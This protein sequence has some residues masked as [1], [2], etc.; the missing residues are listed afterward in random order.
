MGKSIRQTIICQVQKND[1]RQR[2]CKKRNQANTYLPSA[3]CYA[4][5]KLQ[6]VSYVIEYKYFYYVK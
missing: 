4:L 5:N 2:K 1:S 3:Q 6:Q